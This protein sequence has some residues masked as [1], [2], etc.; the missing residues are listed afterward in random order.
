METGQQTVDTKGSQNQD[1]T[2]ATAAAMF[3]RDHPVFK[4]VTAELAQTR[5]K[6]E[7]IERSKSEESKKLAIQ[8]EAEKGNYSAALEKAEQLKAQEINALK[9]QYESAMKQIETERATNKLLASGVNNLKAAAFLAREF[10]ALPAE[11]RPTFDAWITKAK[12]DP[13]YEAFFGSKS[14]IQQPADRSGSG[15]A[16]AANDG[17][18]FKEI[19][20]APG[21]FTIS[22]VREATKWRTQYVATHGQMP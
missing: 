9:S 21:K 8:A 7:E 22:E 19:L 20:A 2:A 12:V 5:Q 13:D 18:K 17:A 15:V 4:K 16:R 1:A 14:A 3:D 6:L 11:D 10:D